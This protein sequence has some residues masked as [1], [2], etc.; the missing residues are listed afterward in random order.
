MYMMS[1]LFAAYAPA[2]RKGEI[3]NH[4]PNWL[5]KGP[6]VA[7]AV[8]CVTVSV[9]AQPLLALVTKLLGV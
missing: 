8:L 3:E 9:L 4:D 6:L 7:L 1:I 5:M 2:F